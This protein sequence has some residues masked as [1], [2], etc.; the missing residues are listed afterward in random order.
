MAWSINL[1]YRH[2]SSD[3]PVLGGLK[4]DTF[5]GYVPSGIEETGGAM[6]E[7]PLQ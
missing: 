1:I 3:Q 7:D 5:R 4:A 2:L 6:Q